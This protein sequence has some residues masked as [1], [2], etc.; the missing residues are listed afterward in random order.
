M[1]GIPN[2]GSNLWIGAPGDSLE[3]EADLAADRVMRGAPAFGHSQSGAATPRL[4]AK[5]GAQ[6]GGI[7]APASVKDALRSPGA[8]LDSG[9]RA[10]MEPRFGHDFSTVRVHADDGAAKAADAI[11]A[12]AFT[13]GPNLV[14]G[15]GQY[16]PVSA[17]GKHLLAHEL[18]HVVQQAGGGG[19]HVQMKP[20][21]DPLQDA[22]AAAFRK[23]LERSLPEFNLKYPVAKE[24]TE[25]FMAHKNAQLQKEI[26]RRSS[27]E[28]QYGTPEP[29]PQYDAN[30]V[31][32]VIWEALDITKIKGGKATDW[33]LVPP[34]ASA[35][36]LSKEAADAGG[37]LEH[38]EN[39]ASKKIGKVS[40]RIGIGMGVLR[41]PRGAL[42]DYATDKAGEAI[43][44]GLR[45]LAAWAEGQSM[46]KL[47]AVLAGGAEAVAFATI[48]LGAAEIL[49]ALMD[50][51]EAE[52]K[53]EKRL[54]L[55]FEVKDWL[56][57]KR[58]RSAKPS[59]S[60]LIIKQ[61]P[62]AKDHARVE[63]RR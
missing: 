17:G 42:E 4:Q 8:P 23:M 62:L 38:S 44:G 45:V 37:M 46:L 53:A 36:G 12:R 6:A 51:G 3:R 27:I 10:F 49:N 22:K 29:L 30:E 43:E 40:K 7:A 24:L 39:K 58:F 19:A 59:N 15:R 34:Q 18:A 16:D 61:P 63:P 60:M 1:S 31:N 50:A 47:T 33:D 13:S 41:D 25:G 5:A 52:A 32:A 21:T 55:L 28:A 57:A 54:A 56:D 14:F 26:D 2:R 11:G 48:V 9:T 35:P 20:K